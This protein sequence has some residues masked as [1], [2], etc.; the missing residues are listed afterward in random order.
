MR[1]CSVCLR[2]VSQNVRSHLNPKWYGPM[3]P[4]R[5]R[6]PDSMMLAH[7][8]LVLSRRSRRPRQGSLGSQWV[9]GMFQGIVQAHWWF[10]ETCTSIQHCNL[11]AHSFSYHTMHLHWCGLLVSVSRSRDSHTSTCE[12][13]NILSLL[14]QKKMFV[15]L[16]FSLGP[17]QERLFLLCFYSI[18]LR[19]YQ[20]MSFLL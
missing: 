12:S 2:T 14:E 6:R 11:S 1:L 7:F 17:G 19:N 20:K 13:Q 16:C 5:R 4:C 8:Q 9:V 18:T 3:Y 15:H 10:Q